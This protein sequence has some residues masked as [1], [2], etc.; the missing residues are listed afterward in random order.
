MGVLSLA[1][2]A[3]L[4]GVVLGSAGPAGATACSTSSGNS[5]CTIGTS[6]AVSAGTLTLE[7]SPNLYWS[8]VLNGY[9]QWASG[10]SA[11]LSGCT[12][13]GSGTTCSGGAAPRLEVVDATGSGS[14]WALSAYLTANDLPVGSVFHFAGAG[15]A[16][17]GNSQ[18]AAIGTDPFANTTPGTVCDFGSTCTVPTAPG[19]C[20]HA[21]LGFTS[22]PTYPVNMSAGT[23]PTAQVDLYSAA[24]TSGL[25][26][27]CFGSGSA[28]AS[29]CTG[30]TPSDF[31]N[32]GVKA[33][34]AAAVD[35][36]TVVT[37]TVSSGP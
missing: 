32:I 35:A 18:N 33:N 4:G 16:T 17:V 28:S 29:G 9:D 37:E 2:L 25:G 23:G 27:V 20:S 30:T 6:V 10:S 19:A 7:S 3:P 13:G 12:A 8:Y 22:C 5:S 14:G 15:S 11:T 36:T 24:A 31:Y 34:T 1:P 21:G 26:A